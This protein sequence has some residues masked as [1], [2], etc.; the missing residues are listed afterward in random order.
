MLVFFDDTLIYIKTLATHLQHVDKSLELLCDHQLF[1]KHSK[2]CS[3]G[4]SEVKYSGHTIGKDGV[5]MEPKK[6]V[7]MQE[8]TC[9]K[10]LKSLHGFFGLTGYYRKFVRN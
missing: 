1:I 7:A 10:T 8:R 3:F 4:V 2:H 6:I 9:L 5:R